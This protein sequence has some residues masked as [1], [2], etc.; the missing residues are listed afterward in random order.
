MCR[1]L[2]EE[3]WPGGLEAVIV[4]AVLVQC[5]ELFQSSPGSGALTLCV[6]RWSVV[7]ANNADMT[8]VDL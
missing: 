3:G 1:A 4:L 5:S 6:I 2:L 8:T 7:T